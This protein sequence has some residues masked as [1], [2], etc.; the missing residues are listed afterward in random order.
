MNPPTRPATSWAS[1]DWHSRVSL[2]NPGGA[3]VVTL[4]G[5]C[6][7]RGMR[8]DTRPCSDREAGDPTQA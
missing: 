3:L 2:I 1:C 7:W 5:F 8:V 6:V 4:L